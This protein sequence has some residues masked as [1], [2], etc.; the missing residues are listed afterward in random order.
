MNRLALSVGLSALIAG[1]GGIAAAAPS[2]A[3]P[4]E[5]PTFT[6]DVAPILLKNCASCHRPGEV[7]PMSLLT[8]QDARPWSKAIKEKVVSR[9]MPP[10]FADRTQG[11]KLRNDRSLTEQEIQTIVAWVDAGAPKGH[12]ADLPA[13]PRFAAGWSGGAPDYIVEV[14]VEFELPAEGQI[15]LQDFYVPVPFAEDR[16]AEA[17][18]M[19]P[20]NY[21]VV[22]HARINL[23]SL[24][25]GAK[26]VGV[27]ASRP[28][29]PS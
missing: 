9:E 24:P 6:K 2:S 15:D 17:L 4:P 18:E 23:Q 28:M 7:A 16:F 29:A 19:R 14:P 1:S 25:E 11:R 27:G 5:A 13:L 20:G 10:W 12:D 21:A 8:Y 26:I 22:H 3:S